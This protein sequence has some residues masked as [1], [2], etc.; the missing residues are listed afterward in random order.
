MLLPALVTRDVFLTVYKMFSTRH[1][2]DNI[3]IFTVD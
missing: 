1:F 2:E 3:I